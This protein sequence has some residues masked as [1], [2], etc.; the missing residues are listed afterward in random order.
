MPQQRI[1]TGLSVR[2][3]HAGR[4]WRFHTVQSHG[5]QLGRV[6]GRRSLK[7]RTGGMHPCCVSGPI[8]QCW[9]FSLLSLT[10]H[11]N[12][13]QSRWGTFCAFFYS[14]LVYSTRV[15]QIWSIIMPDRSTFSNNWDCRD[16]PITTHD[17]DKQYLLIKTP[18]SRQADTDQEGLLIKA[19]GQFAACVSF[20]H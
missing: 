14:V 6:N 9:V 13:K 17:L 16:T 18:I 12:Q 7:Q 19:N 4:M 10:A 2:G 11:Q 1:P 15:A 20:T 8:V 3:S 5:L